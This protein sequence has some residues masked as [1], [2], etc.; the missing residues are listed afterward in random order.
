[1]L[2]IIEPYIQ[3]QLTFG[4]LTLNRMFDLE[5]LNDALA[6]DALSEAH[7][8]LNTAV[9][10]EHWDILTFIFRN[11]FAA[12]KDTQ[13]IRETL[14][15][16]ED[17]DVPDFVNAYRNRDNEIYWSYTSG[18]IE[19][20][21]TAFFDPSKPKTVMDIGCGQGVFL[22]ETA[23]HEEAD[24]LHGIEIKED[25]A[26]VTRMKML[27]LNRDMNCIR[28]EDVFDMDFRDPELPKY[29]AV[30]CH[31][32]IKQKLEAKQL[33]S[34]GLFDAVK[35]AKRVSARSS[36]WAY[37]RAMR[38]MM[39]KGGKGIAFIRASLLYLESEQEFR[40]ELLESGML[41]GVVLLPEGLLLHTG[42]Q[43]A[44]LVLSENN[45]RVKM[46]NAASYYEKIRFRNVLTDTER[47]R[48]LDLYFNGGSNPGDGNHPSEDYIEVAPRT[49]ADNTYS[50]DPMRY[51]LDE[52]VCFTSARKLS[53]GT[54]EIFRGA[55][56]SSDKQKAMA[57]LCGK[58]PNG[59]LLTLANISNGY[60]D[61]ELVEVHIDKIEKYKKYMLQEGDV[62]ISARGTKISTAVAKNINDRNI[63][64]TGNLIVVRCNDTL[65]PYYLKAFFDSDEGNLCLSV[66]QT[67]STIFA[68]N[69]K[70]LCELQYDAL[71]MEKQKR[72]AVKEESLI[73]ELRES[74]HRVE[75]LRRN[76]AGVYD[77][78]KE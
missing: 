78:F 33:L 7:E 28:C 14:D 34:C 36:E 31:M 24:E 64:A 52:K 48:I 26:M 67:G 70:Q 39:K 38:K 77:C 42:I 66:A 46:V 62:I 76:I 59:Y 69:P 35:T 51:V 25:D 20:L 61:E 17:I 19:K 15:T 44:M 8:T 73:H 57:N 6:Q 23:I 43:I 10:P 65:E 13:R 41:E 21:A 37:I 74:I 40:K 29:D 49:I 71:D 63:I 58:A 32:P 2:K 1:M 3:S 45:D 54:R 22:T 12:E 27:I 50:F 56:I 60:M 55:Q 68:I 30:F 5:T 18:D 72:I 4:V 9:R 47:D 53:E 16:I 11:L 75:A